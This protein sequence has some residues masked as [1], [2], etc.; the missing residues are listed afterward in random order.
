MRPDR[1][2]MVAHG[3]IAAFFVGKVRI[4]QPLNISGFIIRSTTRPALSSSAIPVQS[5]WPDWTT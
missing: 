5:A 1:P 4:P 3:I 2:Q